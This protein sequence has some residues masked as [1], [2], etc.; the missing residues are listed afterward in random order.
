MGDLVE[1]S[2]VYAIEVAGQVHGDEQ[3]PMEIGRVRHCVRDEATRPVSI[4]ADVRKERFGASVFAHV[5]V[6]QAGQ[7]TAGR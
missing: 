3:T 5:A 4:T 1:A 6:G 2:K 7:S